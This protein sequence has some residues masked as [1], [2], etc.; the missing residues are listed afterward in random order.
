MCLVAWS[1]EQHARFPLVLA[2]NRDEFHERP[3][4]GLGWWPARPD[5][6]QILA[7]RDLQAGGTWF[8]LGSRGRLALLTNI[9]APQRQRD[10]APTRGVIVPDWLDSPLA[11]EELWVRTAMAGHNGFNLVNIDL[12]EGR[13]HWMSSDRSCPQRLEAGLYGLSNGALDEPWPKVVALKAALAAATQDVIDRHAPRERLVEQ[14]LQALQQRERAHDA[15]LPATGVPLEIERGLSAICIDMP[16]RGYGTRSSTVLVVE[17]LI[18][19]SAPRFETTLVER[20]MAHAGHPPVRRR[21]TL[22]HWPP[23]PVSEPLL[24]PLGDDR[25]H[26]PASVP[27]GDRHPIELQVETP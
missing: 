18:D 17:R 4:A 15:A 8:G 22:P 2:S 12:V 3:T 5:G 27:P 20:S 25:G 26:A 1:I 9:R 14:L 19:G 10:D 23:I 21:V 7:G 13:S 6:R 24:V 11:P 16:E